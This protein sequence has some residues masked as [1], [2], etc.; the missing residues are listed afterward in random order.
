MTFAHTYQ[1]RSQRRADQSEP[2]TRALAARF[3]YDRNNATAR[4]G[5]GDIFK[6]KQ[7]VVVFSGLALAFHL[8][9]VQPCHQ[10][11]HDRSIVDAFD[12]LLFNLTLHALLVDPDPEAQGLQYDGQGDSAS[13][14][15][16][17]EFV[18][19]PIVRL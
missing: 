5:V 16:T 13:V 15:A 18:F 4:L 19:V 8:V 3:H 1:R 7:A 9:N 6:L 14:V 17:A 11:D 2:V 12:H 10:H